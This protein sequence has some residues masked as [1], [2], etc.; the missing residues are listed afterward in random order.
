MPIS[1]I[2]HAGYTAAKHGVV[3]LTR[4]HLQLFSSL[5]RAFLVDL[6]VNLAL[7]LVISY[8]LYLLER[9]I[10]SNQPFIVAMIITHPSLPSKQKC[11]LSKYTRTYNT[12]F[13]SQI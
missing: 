2:E 3:A 10:L 8:Y 12:H 4:Y 9:Y 13:S 6:E 7:K 11:L 1:R 5:Q